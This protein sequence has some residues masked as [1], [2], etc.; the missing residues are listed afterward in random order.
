MQPSYLELKLERYPKR[1]K[2]WRSEELLEAHFAMTE[3][4]GATAWSESL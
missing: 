3:A 1:F 4:P 2:K